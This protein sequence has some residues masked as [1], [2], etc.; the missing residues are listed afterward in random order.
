MEPGSPIKIPPMMKTT[1]NQPINIWL[2]SIRMKQIVVAVQ[3]TN[4]H[5]SSHSPLNLFTKILNKIRSFY[6]NYWVLFYFI[7]LFFI[8][9]C[10]KSIENGNSVW[11]ECGCTIETIQ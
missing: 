1:N 2:P 8:S 5:T 4:I 11:L 3:L 7:L 10:I 6:V 9:I